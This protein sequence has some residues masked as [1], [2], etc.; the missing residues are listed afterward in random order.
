MAFRIKITEKSPEKISKQP[1][2]PEKIYTEEEIALIGEKYKQETPDVPIDIYKKNLVKEP[3]FTR[4]TIV[5]DKN[6][7]SWKI[8]RDSPDTR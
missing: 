2:P 7:R 4:E 3:P 6:T 8:S 5:Y 1:S